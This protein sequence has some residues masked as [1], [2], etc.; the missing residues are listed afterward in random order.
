MATSNE[1]NLIP[2]KRRRPRFTLLLLVLLLLTSGAAG[3]FGW[4][5]MTVTSKAT[6]ASVGA[7][8][9]GTS[10]EAQN[11]EEGGS[12]ASGH[13]GSSEGERG[14][15]S[16]ILN[17][18]PFLVNLADHEASRYLRVTIRLRVSTSSTAAKIATTDVLTSRMRDAILGTL[19]TKSS[20]QLVTQEGKEEL[21]TEIVEKLNAF[22]P[23]KPIKALYFTDFLVQL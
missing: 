1:I 9:E 3:F 20:T 5:Y 2:V 12:P 19:T 13:E 10:A 11:T 21:K 7:P 23:G 15:A 8:D 14:A 22:L 4:K 17:F 6:T 16:T 18:E